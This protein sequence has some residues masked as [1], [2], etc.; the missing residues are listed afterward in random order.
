[1]LFQRDAVEGAL[2]KISAVSGKEYLNKIVQVGLDLPDVD[3]VLLHDFLNTQ[4]SQL[5][6]DAGLSDRVNPVRWGSLFH[7]GFAELFRNLRDVFRFLS[8]IEFQLGVLRQKNVPEVDCVDL[9]AL[10]A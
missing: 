2:E 3:R 7:S 5:L 1:L 8:S 10:E 9:I 6:K 4:L